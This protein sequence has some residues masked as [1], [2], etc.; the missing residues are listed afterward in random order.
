MVLWYACLS[1]VHRGFVDRKR[2]VVVQFLSKVYI[3][4]VVRNLFM[5]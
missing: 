1:K 2:E 3:N 5:P 4:R